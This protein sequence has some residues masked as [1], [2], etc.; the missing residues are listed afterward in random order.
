MSKN[1]SQKSLARIGR[2]KS[3]SGQA[4]VEMALTLVLFVLLVFGILDAGRLIWSYSVVSNA[5]REAVRYAIVRGENSGDDRE[6]T[7]GEIETIARQT[8]IG[9]TPL[10]VN[11]SWDPDN[12][13]GSTVRVQVAYDFRPGVNLYTFTSIRLASVSEM[14][15]S[16]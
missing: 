11:V 13:P 8:A 6:A 1:R 2:L 10:E 9:L 14:V 7:A 15:I 16:R 5:A 3:E 12:E 4:L